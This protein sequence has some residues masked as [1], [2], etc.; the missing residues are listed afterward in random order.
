MKTKTLMI[1]LIL[2]ALIAAPLAMAEPEGGPRDGRGPRDG[3]PRGGRMYGGGGGP[4]GGMY[5]GGMHG[6]GFGGGFGQ[7]L[8]GRMAEKLELTDDQKTQIKAIVEANKDNVEESR[9]A[10]Q[11][12]MKALHQASEGGVEAEVIAAGKALGDAFTEQ[13]L[14]RANIAKQI[15]EVLTDEELAQ[16]E[17]MKAGMK[18]RMQQRRQQGRGGK[19][20][21]Q[22]R[23]ERKGKKP[24]CTGKNSTCTEKK[25]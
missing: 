24:A 15:K 16:L 20:S 6:G 10:I 2:L 19:E 13:A 14:Q 17:E 11:E 21:Y 9:Q 4:R 25:E 1:G 3:G 12:A 18:E 5:G 7:M 23:R 22:G 8:L